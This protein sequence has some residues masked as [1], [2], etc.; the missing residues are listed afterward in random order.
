MDELEVGKAQGV[1]ERGAKAILLSSGIL[2]FVGGIASGL[3]WAIVSFGIGVVL[4][5]LAFWRLPRVYATWALR[6]QRERI[7]VATMLLS[8]FFVTFL[9]F[10]MAGFLLYFYINFPFGRTWDELPIVAMVGVA[11]LIDLYAL[12]TNSVSW[13]K[14]D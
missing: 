5:I 2:V 4:A 10:G 14:K 8:L 6:R 1:L 11:G 12:I 13:L 9:T 3:F 7:M